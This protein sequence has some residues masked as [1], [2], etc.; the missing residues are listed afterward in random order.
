MGE[1]R[2]TG[3]LEEVNEYMDI[4]ANDRLLG[5]LPEGTLIELHRALG[6]AVSVSQHMKEGED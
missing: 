6:T 1:D 3:V 5:A 2:K 4:L